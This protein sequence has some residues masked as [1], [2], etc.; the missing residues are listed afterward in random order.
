ML[1]RFVELVVKVGKPK[2]A[3]LR[4][5]LAG[6]RLHDFSY[7]LQICFPE[8]PVVEEVDIH[9]L[10]DHLDNATV[11]VAEL[12]VFCNQISRLGLDFLVV[13]LYLDGV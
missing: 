5:A 11:H 12:A 7:F 13:L 10:I 1:E 9:E 2:F 6:H 3:V 4:G 8:L